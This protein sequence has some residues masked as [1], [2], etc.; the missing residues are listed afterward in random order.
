MGDILYREFKP[1]D[2]EAVSE[3]YRSGMYKVLC[4]FDSNAW[5]INSSE[6]INDMWKFSLE[7]QKLNI[8]QVSAVTASLQSND[9]GSF[10]Q[11]LLR[12]SK[13]KKLLTQTEMACPSMELQ[14]DARKVMVSMLEEI[15][16]IA[17]LYFFP[18]LAAVK[19]NFCQSC[20]LC[21]ILSNFLK[22]R[23]I[24]LQNIQ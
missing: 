5:N 20:C 23:H 11:P 14:P 4:W 15:S 6:I 3:L 24:E 1:A 18:M 22:H 10:N 19:R 13:L 9:I 21:L 12:V 8:V 17:S 7:S 16:T 2:Q